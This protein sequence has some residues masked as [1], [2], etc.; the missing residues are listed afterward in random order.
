MNFGTEINTVVLYAIE[1]ILYTFLGKQG[2]TWV[3]QKD[4]RNNSK[5]SEQID[6]W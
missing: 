4:E 5:I 1:I 6:E 2:M 3:H